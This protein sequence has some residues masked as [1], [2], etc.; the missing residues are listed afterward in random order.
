MS[1]QEVFAGPPASLGKHRDLCLQVGRDAQHLQFSAD[2][3]LSRSVYLEFIEERRGQWTYNVDFVVPCQARGLDALRSAV[4]GT[5]LPLTTFGK[6]LLPI[7]HTSTRDGSG[8]HVPLETTVVC[9]QFA[10][11]VLLAA[12]DDAHLCLDCLIPLLWQVT[13]SDPLDSECA[14]RKLR[15]DAALNLQPCAHLPAGP[16][17]VLE[18]AGELLMALRLYHRSVPVLMELS[19]HQGEVGTRNSVTMFCDGPIRVTRTFTEIIGWNPLVVAPR[20]AFGGESSSYHVQLVP[21]QSVSVVDS[22]LL[23]SYYAPELRC[24]HEDNDERLRESGELTPE[25]APDFIKNTVTEDWNEY[26]GHVWGGAEPL[27]AHIRCGEQRMPQLREGR[28]AVASFRIY[29]QFEGVVSEILW[30]AGMNWLFVVVLFIAIHWGHYLENV[31][32]RHPEVIFIAAVL[33]AGLGAGF[34]LYPR[35]HVLTSAVLRPWRRLVALLILLTI[36][37][38]ITLVWG[39]KNDA[40]HI[41]YPALWTELVVSTGLMV[42]LGAISLRPYIAE[43]TGSPLYRLTGLPIRRMAVGRRSW[44]AYLALDDREYVDEVDTNASA[45]SGLGRRRKKHRQTRI[46]EARKKEREETRA[47]A[48][49]YLIETARRKLFRR[50]IPPSVRHQHDQRGA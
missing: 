36:V 12:A 31:T 46:R 32:G 48:N 45:C 41:F 9:R 34:L 29:P 13:S 37:T 2:W 35:E 4:S 15:K 40:L 47:S 1:L 22:R 26:W 8:H 20:A 39:S 19:E 16:Q 50:G 5:V 23:Y 17:A 33:V 44:R 27:S 7:A 24:G 3:C 30:A 49:Q 42:F 43:T 21:P 6:D 38:P 18:K 28:D 25:D 11:L 14:Y 10:Y